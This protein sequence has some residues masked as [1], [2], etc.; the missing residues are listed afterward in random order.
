MEDLELNTD[1]ARLTARNWSTEFETF[2]NDI[3]NQQEMYQDIFKHHLYDE[4]NEKI[5]EINQIFHQIQGQCQND[6]DDVKNEMRL[7]VYNI[8][9]DLYKQ[10]LYTKRKEKEYKRR[11]WLQGRKRRK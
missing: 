8:W 7:G 10:E 4:I 6:I 3:Q 11:I 5:N 2:K 9:T 1:L